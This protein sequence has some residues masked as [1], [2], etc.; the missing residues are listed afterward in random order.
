MLLAYMKKTFFSLLLVPFL[1]MGWAVFANGWWWS[2]LQNPA[3]QWAVPWS[4]I[5]TLGNETISVPQSENTNVWWTILDAIKK[6][7][8]Y[9]LWLLALITLIFL[10][11]WWLQMLFNATDDAWYKKWFTILKNAAIALAFIAFSWL[12]VSFIFF[13]L[14][15]VT[16]G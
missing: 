13:V 16:T 6:V 11:V 5:G 1:L 10:I 2:F 3:M 15:L 9:V 4:D 12:L 7:I 14:D 8:N